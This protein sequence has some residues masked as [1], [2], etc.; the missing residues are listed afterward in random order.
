MSWAEKKPIGV[1]LSGYRYQV[2]P[3]YEIDQILEKDFVPKAQEMGADAIVVTKARMEEKFK[4]D[5]EV[6]IKKDVR[7][8]LIKY[9]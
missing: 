5:Y 8:L 2:I 3:D 6:K 9:K 1:A 4:K 7:A